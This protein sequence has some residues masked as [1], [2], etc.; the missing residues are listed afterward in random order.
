MPKENPTTIVSGIIDIII[1]Q[2]NSARVTTII[3]NNAL[4]EATK[5]IKLDTILAN[6]NKYF[7]TYT[8]LIKEA[9][10]SIEVIEL[11]VASLKK[12]NI[13]CPLKT[14]NGKF[15]TSNL[16]IFEKTIERI[17]IIQRGFNTVHITPKTDRL[18]FILISLDTNSVNK[19]LNL[20]KLSIYFF[21][22]LLQFTYFF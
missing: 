15:S 7:G 11:V 10:K 3:T 5:L 9:L 22:I 13:T 16:K 2:C 12:L 18:Y 20:K 19:G 8:F 21:T 17:T 14:Y 4:N 1:S 6:T